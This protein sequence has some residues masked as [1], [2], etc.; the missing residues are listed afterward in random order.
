MTTPSTNFIDSMTLAAPTTVRPPI[1]MAQNITS[2]IRVPGTSDSSN[3]DT[4]RLSTLV[5]VVIAVSCGV[6]AVIIGLAV[7]CNIWRKRRNGR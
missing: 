7:G 1:T 6:A 5:I 4:N 3:V 2:P